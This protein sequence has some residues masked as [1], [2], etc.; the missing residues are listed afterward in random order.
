MTQAQLRAELRKMIGNPTVDEVPDYQI[1]PYLDEAQ[2]ALN[3]RAGFN[4]TDD[5]AAVT[6]VNGTQEY[7]LPVS[8]V[9]ILHV[10]WNSTFLNRSDQDEYRRRGIEFRA[11]AAGTP[12]EFYHYGNLIGLYPKP[13]A[14]AV[15]ADSTLTIRY[16]STPA[17]VPTSGPAQLATQ[18]HRLLTVYAAAKW[19]AVH[20]QSSAQPDMAVSSLMKIFNDE[21]ELMTAQHRRRKIGGK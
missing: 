7:A 2:E 14:A 10:E 18:D 21:A 19:I 5:A 6:I 8:C 1:D 20:P 4:Y 11:T 17:T 15:S 3:R 16:I 13:D 12:T 9:E